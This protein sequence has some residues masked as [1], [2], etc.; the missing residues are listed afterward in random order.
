[1]K[2]P[3]E[4]KSSV[5]GESHVHTLEVIDAMFHV[6]AIDDIFTI[7]LACTMRHIYTKGIVWTIASGLRRI[8]Y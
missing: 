5:R 1:M 4:C 6:H 3:Q 2:A 7:D 8:A